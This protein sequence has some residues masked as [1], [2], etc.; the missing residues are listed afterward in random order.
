MSRDAK[1]KKPQKKHAGPLAL[2]GRYGMLAAMEAEEEGSQGE[3]G[4][5]AHGG[6]KGRH[7]AAA[8]A[9]TAV[10]KGPAAQSSRLVDSP[11][12]STAD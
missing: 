10:S 11:E 1:K 3:R 8:A 2:P 6:S 12:I 4:G 9:P 7:G 5:N